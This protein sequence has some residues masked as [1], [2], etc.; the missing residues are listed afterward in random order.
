M[1]KRDTNNQLPLASGVGL[2]MIKRNT[3]YKLLLAIDVRL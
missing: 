3:N 1:L 2:P